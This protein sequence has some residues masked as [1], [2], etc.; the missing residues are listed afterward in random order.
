MAEPL[1]ATASKFNRI[2]GARWVDKII[3]FVAVLPIVLS[4][5]ALVRA[6]DLDIPRLVLLVQ[7][8]V[9]ALTLVVRRPPVR[10]TT[11]PV[12]WLLA[13]VVTYWPF[14]VFDIYKAG[15][16]LTPTWLSNGVALLSFAVSVWARLSLGRNIGFVPA[17]RQIVTTGA[18]AYV[19]HP[20]YSGL[21]IAVLASEF[22][23]FSWRNLALDVLWCG[24]LL[25]KTF[26]EEGFLR[27]NPEYARYKERVRWRWIPGLA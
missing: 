16:P 13:F 6:G 1:P 18:Y 11:N 3:A 4:I 20:I 17:E 8:A 14:G 19:R 2:L 9:I 15:A 23:R 5:W 12:F 27:Q 21:F 10:V 7:L 26:I 24:L 22:S 25:I